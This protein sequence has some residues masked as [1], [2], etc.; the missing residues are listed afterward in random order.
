MQYKDL[1]DPAQPTIGRRQHARLRTNFA[2]KI[3]SISL[4]SY[5]HLIDLSLSGA[6]FAAP[7]LI[8]PG[9]EVLLHWHGSSALGKISWT[10]HRQCGVHFV[11]QISHD[12]LLLAR[13]SGAPVP[14]SRVQQLAA[15]FTREREY[16]EQ[17]GA[18]LRPIG[19]FVAQFGRFGLRRI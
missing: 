17:P 16:R 1:T 13:A 15:E 3:T 9:I 2:V 19:P 14:L 11:D 7:R 10:E 4:T 6:K 8:S 18:G 12:D 5:G